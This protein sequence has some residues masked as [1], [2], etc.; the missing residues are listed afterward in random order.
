MGSAIARD[1]VRSKDVE[2]VVVYDI[3]VDRLRTLARIESSH[4]LQVKRHDVRR[5]SET[6]DLLEEFHN[7]EMFLAYRGADLGIKSFL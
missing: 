7:L 1:L 4:K 5:G 6:V 3:D 2:K